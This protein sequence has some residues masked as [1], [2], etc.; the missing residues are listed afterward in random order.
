M[1][2]SAL[3]PPEVCTALTAIVADVLTSTC[4]GA[5]KLTLLPRTSTEPTPAVILALSVVFSAVLNLSC[6]VSPAVTFLLP[7]TYIGLAGVTICGVSG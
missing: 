1:L 5:V 4:S 6:V 3:S 2:V 7:L